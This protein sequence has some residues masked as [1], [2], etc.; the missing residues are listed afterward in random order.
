MFLILGL[1]LV[2]SNDDDFVSLFYYIF[3]GSNILLFLEGGLD[4]VIIGMIKIFV[5]ENF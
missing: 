5:I 1:V 4:V 3:N 2:I